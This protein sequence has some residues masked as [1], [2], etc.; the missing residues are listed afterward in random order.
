[1]GREAEAEKKLIF[2]LKE[3]ALLSIRGNL[4]A[5]PVEKLFSKMVLKT[6]FKKS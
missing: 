3:F 5:L 2:F 6:F 1:V 4:K